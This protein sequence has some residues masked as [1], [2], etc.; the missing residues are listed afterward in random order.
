MNLLPREFTPQI[1]LLSLVPG[2]VFSGLQLGGFLGIFV[3][4]AL[5][6]RLTV[7]QQGPMKN[8]K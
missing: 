6:T 7:V 8:I 1:V 5:L 4:S 3:N 2:D